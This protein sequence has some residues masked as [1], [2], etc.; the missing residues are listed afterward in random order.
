MSFTTKK[1]TRPVLFKELK[2]LPTSNFTTVRT[3]ANALSP[4]AGL[5]SAKISALRKYLGN[6]SLTS[7][8]AY[9][10]ARQS[11]NTLLTALKD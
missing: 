3:L 4:R 6:R 2:K 9:T 10:T 5:Q 7:V 1:Y 8:F 11:K